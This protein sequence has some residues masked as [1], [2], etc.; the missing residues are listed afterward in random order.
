M[1]QLIAL[2]PRKYRE[3]HGEEISTLY[4][5]STEHAGPAARFREAADIAA[6]A[7]RTRLG[8]TS[9]HYAG[10]VIAA[11]S[12]F[13]LATL[14]GQQ[15]AGLPDLFRAG[16][17][18]GF[19]GFWWPAAAAT[20]ALAAAVICTLMGLWRSSRLLVAAFAVLYVLTRAQTGVLGAGAEPADL[21]TAAV[22]LLALGSP[23]DLQPLP[24]S[25]RFTLGAVSAGAAAVQVLVFYGSTPT[26]LWQ[27]H[28]AA[29]MVTVLTIAL[30][31]AALRDRSASP[32]VMGILLAALIWSA[33]VFLGPAGNTWNVYA[34]LAV[35]TAVAVAAAVLPRLRPGIAG[36]QP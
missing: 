10:R 4:A 36:R 32:A 18:A 15:V 31:V 29:T 26:G 30:A 5:H 22:L 1:T 11:A 27:I 13:L 28:P 23:P 8:T 33:S 7:L 19:P 25:T 12:P 35:A 2:Y 6:H 17:S 14:A 24:R 34:P 3:A 9:A 20:V 21:L 16:R